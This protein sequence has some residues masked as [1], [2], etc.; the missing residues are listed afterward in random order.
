MST[1]DATLANL[2]AQMHQDQEVLQGWDAVMNLLE[3]SV[4]AFFEEQWKEQSGGGGKMSISTIWCDGVEPFHGEH[5]TNVTQLQVDLGPPLFQFESGQSSVTVRQDVLDGT[6]RTG[7]M[8]VP[9]SFQ[10][11][12]CGCEIDDSRVT[13]NPPVTIDTSSK[14]YLSG[15]VALEQV[16]GV[17]SGAHSLV[18]D[19]AKGAFTLEHLSVEH[20]KNETI[21]DQLKD[22]FATHA[23]RYVLASIDFQDVTGQAGFTPTSFKFGVVTTD[24]GNT[25]VQ[26]L[27]TTN[28]TEPPTAQINVDEP[29]PTADG[30]TCSLMV[31][32][33]ILYQDV[34]VAGFNRHGAAFRLYADPPSSPSGAW[35][36]VISPEMHFSGKF[37]FGSCCDRTTVTYSIY[38]GGRYTGSETSGFS[39]SQHE[40]TEGNVHVEISVSALYPVA[41]SG[42]GAQQEI[43]IHPGTPSVRVTGSAEGKIKSRLEAILNDDLRGS[44]A[45]ISFTPVTYFALKNLLF[46]GNLI[47]M[48]QVQVPA[49]LLVVGTFEPS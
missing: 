8:E 3:S 15:T 2:L 32:S 39:L 28:G 34:L 26:L 20:V 48:S 47:K 18:L 11:P 40:R 35:T 46:P 43:T 23:I 33:R 14:P 42:S 31:S 12:S 21:V 24:A 29:V 7:V 36:A 19:F 25:I 44:M 37:S 45:G 22:W 30:L 6:S 13:W 41:L 49:D 9:A 10:P 27:I 4:N 16:E 1:S 17:V 38:L 5:V